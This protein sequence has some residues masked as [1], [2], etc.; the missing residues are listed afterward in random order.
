MHKLA[1]RERNN[2]AHLEWKPVDGG[3]QTSYVGYEQEHKCKLIEGT[4]DDPV[5]KVFYREIHYTKQGSTVAEAER[6]PP[7][8]TEIIEVQEI[9]HY[10]KGKWDF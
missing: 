6:N 10:L 7:K 4:E 5:A 2:L 9:F 3:V 1:E 8:P